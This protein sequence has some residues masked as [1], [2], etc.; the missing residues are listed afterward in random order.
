MATISP[1]KAFGK[2]SPSGAPPLTAR[3]A[4]QIA[5]PVGRP[6][7][8]RFVEARPAIKIGEST[9]CVDRCA[10][11]GDGATIRGSMTLA[12]L[13]A[14]ALARCD[15]TPTRHGRIA[16]RRWHAR[17]VV[18]GRNGPASRDR[19]RR[20][21]DRLVGASARNAGRPRRATTSWSAS[22]A[23]G[24]VDEAGIAELEPA[25]ASLLFFRMRRISIRAKRWRGSWMR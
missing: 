11:S 25:L 1:A 7:P 19:G 17:P 23:H 16:L 13:A 6:A 21:S 18:R 15:H 8:N 10:R 2:H 12:G 14:F 9:W 5:K 3:W 20:K 24:W 4:M 22:P